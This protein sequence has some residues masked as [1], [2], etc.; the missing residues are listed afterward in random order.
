MPLQIDATLL[1]GQDPNLPFDTLKA[2]NSPYNTYLVQGLPP[3]PIANPGRKSIEA[4]LNPAPN[5]DPTQC[6]NEQAVRLALLRADRQDHRPA[7][8]RHEP[9]RP[10]GQR[11]QGQGRRRHPLSPA[12]TD[13]AAERDDRVAAV[14]GSPVRHSLSPVLHNAAFAALG[15]DWASSP[16]RSTRVRGEQALRGAAALGLAGLS[17]TMPLKD[18]AARV[19]DELT[20]MAD[21]LGAVNCVVIEAGRLIGHNTDGAGLPRRPAG[22]ARP[23][24]ASS[25][26]APAARPGPSSRRP[27]GAGAA[28]VVVVNRTPARGEVAAVAGRRGRPAGPGGR[29][30]GRRPRRERHLG[31]HGRH[32][33]PAVPDP[34]S[35]PRRPGGG[36][37]RVPPGRHRLAGGRRGRQ[38]ATAVD[39]VGMLV[40][41]A[42]HAFRLWTGQAAPV[43]VMEAAARARLG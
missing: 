8:L 2:L 20:P 40:H 12:V 31:R 14:L 23:G 36:R 35:L 7:R 4:A 13:L 26:S 30:R 24:A 6:P 17:V 34:A 27:A 15:L 38:G 37:P 10:R 16:S 25:C 9:G 42:A 41:Q 33:R 5:P 11:G 1:Y 22:L 43:D 39:G 21:R 28:D 18:V 32:G 19:C 3:T 29:H